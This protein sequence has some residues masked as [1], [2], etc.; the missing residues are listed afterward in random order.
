MN[1]SNFS[2]AVTGL[3]KHKLRFVKNEYEKNEILIKNAIKNI[4]IPYIHEGY[5]TFLTGMATGSD[6]M[7]AKAV[8]ELKEDYSII[9]ESVIPFL[10]QASKLSTD[11]ILEYNL[12]LKK[13]D[14]VRIIN[15]EYSKDVY[16][17]RNEYLVKNASVL[18][19]ITD[20]VKTV[21]SGTTSTINKAI[22]EGLEIINLNPYSLEIEKR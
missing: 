5:T 2:I 8:I 4:L 3:R 11:D 9:L 10:E 13:C 15:N 18:L 17:K 7:F 22:K 20:D 1:N 16:D 12:I 21:R 19:A 6:I 14:V